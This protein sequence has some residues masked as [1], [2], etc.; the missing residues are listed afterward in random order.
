MTMRKMILFRAAALLLLLTGFVANTFAQ[1]IIINNISDVTPCAGDTIMVSYTASQV[2]NSNNIYHIEI[3]DTADNLSNPTII[4]MLA[5]V[6]DNSVI[7]GIIPSGIMQDNTY[8]MR[9]V[10]S[11]PAVI[12]GTET[13]HVDQNPG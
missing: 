3:S 12:S 5:S 4:G 10:S 1:T 13:F 7:T 8:L 11:D 6:S 9:I 2:M